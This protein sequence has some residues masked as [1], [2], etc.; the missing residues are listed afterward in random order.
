MPLVWSTS[1]EFGGLSMSPTSVGLWI[2]GYGFINGIF[3]FVALPRM[4]GRFGPRRIFIACIILYFP[5][6][7]L[8]DL[9][10]VAAL[11]IV[12]QLLAT[13]FSDMGFG[14]IFMYISSAAPNKRS[15]GA[16][17]GVAQMM[18]SIQRAIGP[19]AAASL[20]AFSLEN[21]ILGG[22]FVYVVLLAL[23]WVGLCVARQ[24]PKDMWIHNEQ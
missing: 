22:N 14:V 2:S 6:Y 11:L 1:V 16:M 23:V 12:L 21:G 8:R 3:Q 13:S 15:L 5:S 19:A 10:L 7:I 4:V 9:N 20:F 24:L 17:N 18:V